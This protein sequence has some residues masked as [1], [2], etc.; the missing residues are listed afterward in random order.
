[1]EIGRGES[2]RGYTKLPSS[3]NTF[4]LSMVIS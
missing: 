4:M 1:M 2:Q 3:V